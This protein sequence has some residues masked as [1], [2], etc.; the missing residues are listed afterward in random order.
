MI[1]CVA[2]TSFG[3]YIKA[4]NGNLNEFHHRFWA[5]HCLFQRLV[6]Q[7]YVGN[8]CLPQTVSSILREDCYFKGTFS[9]WVWNIYELKCSNHSI[10]DFTQLHKN[11]VLRTLHNYIRISPESES[12]NHLFTGIPMIIH[13]VSLIEPSKHPN[14]TI[15]QIF[16]CF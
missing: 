14:L 15:R 7:I 6:Y 9:R 16:D 11:I 1:F 2:S 10:T 3:M 4:W 8:F 13:N 5:T 12:S